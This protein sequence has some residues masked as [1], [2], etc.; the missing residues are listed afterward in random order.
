MA[1]QTQCCLMIREEYNEDVSDVKCNRY[2][3]RRSRCS[4]KKPGPPQEAPVGFGETEV[5]RRGGAPE[6]QGETE[7]VRRGEGDAQA[8]P[9][10]TAG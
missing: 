6:A 9:G 1:I 8:K 2:V 7:A 4:R 5:R 3:A 10:E